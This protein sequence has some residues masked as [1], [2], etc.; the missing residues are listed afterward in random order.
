MFAALSDALW[1]SQDEGKT[2]QRLMKAPGNITALTVQPEKQETVFA[3]TGDGKL[4]R[5]TD[6]GA[7]WD[8]PR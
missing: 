3:G 7:S 4:F 6:G 1:K 8:A 5:S 2:W